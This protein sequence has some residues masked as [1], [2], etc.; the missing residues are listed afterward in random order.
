M[1]EID[2][3]TASKEYIGKVAGRLAEVIAEK[4]ALSLA[5]VIAKELAAAIAKLP[6]PAPPRTGSAEG[7]FPNY[8]TA[9]GKTIAGAAEGDLRY[10]A[11]GALRS[12]ADPAKERF[13]EKEKALLA[14]I[15]AEL[16]RMGVAP[17]GDTQD[18]G[19]ASSAAPSNDDIPF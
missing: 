4:V 9:K 13:R 17:E 12:I 16:V 11:K 2:F 1:P 15:N 18:E 7:C 19:A 3:S 6:A 14:A 5:P 10:Y 8:G